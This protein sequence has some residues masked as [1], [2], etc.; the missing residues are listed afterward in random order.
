[1]ISRASLAFAK[2][3]TFSKSQA[4]WASISA[5]R[6][7]TAD[8]SWVFTMCQAQLSGK[9]EAAFN[10][11]TNWISST[12]LCVPGLLTALAPVRET[13][14]VLF[15]LLLLFQDRIF[16]PLAVPHT[17]VLTQQW[18]S[19]W[20]HWLLFPAGE[21][22]LEYSSMRPAPNPLALGKTQ[23]SIWFLAASPVVAN[24]S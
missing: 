8:V 6:K 11:Q 10:R 9:C 3:L 15:E 13:Q 14:L 18:Q 7:I 2:N 12:G 1:M 5:S 4:F 17:L 16:E 22:M 24:L 19:P 21:S 23:E 20:P